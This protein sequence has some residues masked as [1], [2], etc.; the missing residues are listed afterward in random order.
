MNTEFASNV[1]EFTECL[2][3]E[4]LENFEGKEVGSD[5]CMLEDIMKFH[6]PD[7]KPGDKVKGKKK[8]KDPNAPKRALTGYT[9][10][11]KMNKEKINAEI[12]KV[13]GDP[14][15]KYVTILGKLWG[16]LGE[17]EQQKWNKKAATADAKA[18]AKAK[19]K[20]EAEAEANDE[21]NGGDGE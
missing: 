3:K 14:P 10:F 6:F 4:F 13:G 16:E 18:K 2:F 8:K 17:S 20:A 1:Y 11:G 21:E 19:A 9:Y 7:Y 5:E 12:A 15:P